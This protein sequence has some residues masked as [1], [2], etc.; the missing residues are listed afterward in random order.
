MVVA[1]TGFFDGVHKGHLSVIEKVYTLARESGGK[2]V[3][4]TFWPHPRAVLQQDAARFRLL[5]SLEEKRE[6][7]LNY[8]IDE[9]VVLEF[10]KEFARQTTRE[11]FRDYLVNKIGVSVLVAGYDHRV[12]SDLSQTQQEMFEIALQEGIRPVRVDEFRSSGVDVKVSSTKIREMISAGEIESANRMLGYRY[13]LS[14]AVVEGRRIGRTLGFPTANMRLYEPLKLLPGDG[15]YAVW[16]GYAGRVFKGITNIGKRPTIANG[17][18]RTIE[19]HIL[20]FDEDIYGL[21]LKIELVSKMRD[22]TKFASVQE[23]T[24]QLKL[25]RDNAANILQDNNIKFR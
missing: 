20:D 8:G 23:L 24:R 21:T 9:V 5:T 4:V 1:T 25:D 7:L 15:V 6:L 11:F 12:G 16:A 3:V 2:S 10:D 14:G 13:G 22:E 18:E 19:T 17:N